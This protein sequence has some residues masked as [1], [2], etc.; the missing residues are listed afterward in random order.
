MSEKNYLELATEAARLERDRN[1]KAAEA[2]WLSA[3][4]CANKGA[5]V[6]WCETRASVCKHRAE[7]NR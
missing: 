6:V 1:Y 4:N 3:Q 5:N 2:M 7:K